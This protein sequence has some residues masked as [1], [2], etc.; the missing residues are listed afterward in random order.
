MKH[1]K[2]SKD[3]P[4]GSTDPASVL[5][6]QMNG[7][8]MGASDPLMASMAHGQMTAMPQFPVMP[9]QNLATSF[10]KSFLLGNNYS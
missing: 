7:A 1:K 5:A 10:N 2:E 3:R 8:M 6:H 4:N 9:F